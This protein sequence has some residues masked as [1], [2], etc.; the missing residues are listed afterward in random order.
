[1]GGMNWDRQPESRRGSFL[2]QR[3]VDQMGFL[4]NH[5]PIFLH[6]INTKHDTLL[7]LPLSH[8]IFSMSEIPPLFLQPSLDSPVPLNHRHASLP[9][10]QED[11]A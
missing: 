9:P 10:N 3:S 1:M 7:N 4:H 11:I 8:A 2:Q 5:W 6:L